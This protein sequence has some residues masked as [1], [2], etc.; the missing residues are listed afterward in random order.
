MVGRGAIPHAIKVGRLMLSFGS[1]PILKQE[2]IRR[3]GLQPQSIV[4]GFLW[5]RETWKSRGLDPDELFTADK[6]GRESLYLA[7]PQLGGFMHEIDPQGD[8]GLVAVANRLR[9]ER[10]QAT[11]DSQPDELDSGPF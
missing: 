10:Q 8:G 6:I 9:E 7:G 1:R 4:R 5:M 11:T 2:I 3:T